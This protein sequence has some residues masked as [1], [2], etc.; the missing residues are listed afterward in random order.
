[1][2]EH[3]DASRVES[4]LS[5]RVAPALADLDDAAKPSDLNLPG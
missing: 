4:D 1:M 5:D 3:G 2:H